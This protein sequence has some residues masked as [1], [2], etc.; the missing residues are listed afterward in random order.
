MCKSVFTLHGI[1]GQDHAV[2]RTSLRRGQ[3]NA[4]FRKLPATEIA[5]EACGG[6]HHWA[7]EVFALGHQARLVPPQYVKPYGR[8]QQSGPSAVAEFAGQ[9]RHLGD[10]HRVADLLLE[11]A[12]LVE[13]K[14]VRALDANH[15]AQCLN[16]RGTGLFPVS[17]PPATPPW[18]KLSAPRAFRPW[19]RCSSPWCSEA[20]SGPPLTEIA[21]LRSQ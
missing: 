2:L 9:W 6:S 8:H 4:F 14:T 21:S 18:S 15:D 16:R 17:S 20:I 19:P 3:M 10:Q 7:R 13:I 5:L 12:V 1:D 11:N